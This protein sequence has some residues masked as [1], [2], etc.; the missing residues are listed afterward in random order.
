L[1]NKSIYEKGKDISLTLLR[2]A[3][4]KLLK[5]DT[6]HDCLLIDESRV[7]EGKRRGKDQDLS[8]PEDITDTTYYY[9]VP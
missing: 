2:V 8:R 9:Y 4:A 1:W 3:G 6:I 7:S 5:R